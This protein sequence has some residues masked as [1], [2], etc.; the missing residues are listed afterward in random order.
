[1]E[2]INISDILISETSTG[3]LI[4]DEEYIVTDIRDDGITLNKGIVISKK[5]IQMYFRKK[6]N[7]L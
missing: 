1:M 2:T 4:K 6:E 5:F 7:V 3:W